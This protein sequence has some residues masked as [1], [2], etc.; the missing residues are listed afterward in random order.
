[1]LKKLDLVK[2]GDREKMFVGLSLWDADT[3]LDPDNLSEKDSRE[4]RSND[5]D[6]DKKTDRENRPETV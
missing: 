5:P 1:L 4:D 3:G 6:F 2:Y